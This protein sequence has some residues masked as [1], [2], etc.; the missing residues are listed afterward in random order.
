MYISER[1]HKNT[2]GG[3]S[4]LRK[5]IWHRYFPTNFVKFL[6]IPFLQN[7]S[8]RLLLKKDGKLIVDAVLMDLWKALDRVFI[9]ELSLDLLVIE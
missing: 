1:L 3:A 9:V 8:R 4:L 6:R 2:Y 7:T 5:R